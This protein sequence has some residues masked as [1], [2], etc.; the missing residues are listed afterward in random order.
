MLLVYYVYCQ[1]YMPRHGNDIKYILYYV[2]GTT[3]MI[4]FYWRKPKL[5]L[6]EYVNVGYL[7]DLYKTRL[8]IMYVFNCNNIVISWRFFKQTMMITSSHHS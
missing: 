5:Q 2:H 8:Q 7:S 3:H 4:L 6:F 1:L